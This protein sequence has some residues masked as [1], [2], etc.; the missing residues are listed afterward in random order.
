ADFAVLADGLQIAA[1]PHVRAG[2]PPRGLSADISG[3]QLLELVVRTS[4]W[5]YCHAVWLD[6]QVGEAAAGP[7]A[8]TLLDCLGRAEIVLPDTLPRA[9]RCIVTAVSPGFERRL[10]DLLGSLHAN[11]GCPDCLLLVFGLNA[12]TACEQVVAKYR[13]TLIR[14]RL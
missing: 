9:E 5:D 2:E 3:A 1:A 7:R 8:G 6:A 12:D 4:R 13:A 14:C 11:G 10:D